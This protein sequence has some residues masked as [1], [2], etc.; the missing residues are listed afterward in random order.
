VQS[1]TTN[2]TGVR[3]DIKGREDLQREALTRAVT[4]ARRRAEAAAAGAG[5][6]IDRIVRIEDAGFDGAP[7]PRP[8][9]MAA[10]AE[11]AAD[12]MTPIAPGELEVRARVS[13]TC[14]LR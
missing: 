3:F 13:V 10:R 12:A 5:R 6:S 2:V 8:M 9:A 14:A 7:Q 4:Q 11:M 1:G